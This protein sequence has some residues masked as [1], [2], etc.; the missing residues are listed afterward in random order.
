MPG[1]LFIPYG[2]TFSDSAHTRGL[3]HNSAACR[4]R[5]PRSISNRIS[6]NT[7]DSDTAHDK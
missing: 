4:P 3:R 6:K 5:T 1:F 2:R 7:A